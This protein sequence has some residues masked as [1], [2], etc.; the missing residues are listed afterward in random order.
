MLEQIDSVLKAGRDRYIKSVREYLDPGYY[1]VSG[2]KSALSKEEKEFAEIYSNTVALH[3]L[4]ILLSF[5]AAVATIRYFR[6]SR[7][8]PLNE[9]QLGWCK[10]RVLLYLPLCFAS[11]VTAYG[12]EVTTD[13]GGRL[14]EIEQFY[15]DHRGEDLEGVSFN[16]RVIRAE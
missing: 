14:K 16:P 15:Q 4:N 6:A 10:R 1:I 12:Y 11:M 7:A 8:S 5:P 3:S 13:F 9:K 2:K